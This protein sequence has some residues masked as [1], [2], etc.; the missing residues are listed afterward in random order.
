M[1]DCVE[2]INKQLKDHNTRI[3]TSMTISR[4]LSTTGVG[5]QVTT[6]KID[7]KIRKPAMSL[8]ASFCPFCGKK[9]G[10]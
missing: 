1:C 2:K 4:D 5:L 7:T 3:S 9:W 10:T 6:H 8:L